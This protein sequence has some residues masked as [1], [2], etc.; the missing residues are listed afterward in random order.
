MVIP[1]HITFSPIY[2]QL[3]HLISITI[4]NSSNKTFVGS[5]HSAIKM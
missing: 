4:Y 1:I 5:C 2:L 3:G